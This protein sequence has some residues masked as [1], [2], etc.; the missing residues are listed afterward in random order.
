MDFLI[1][2]IIHIQCFG[3]LG[4]NG[5]GKTTLF[6]M[7][8]GQIIPT[9]GQAIINGCDIKSLLSTNYQHLGYCPQADALD[10]VL[11][12]L[13]HLQIYAELR[14]IPSDKVKKVNK[15]VGNLIVY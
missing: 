12:P 10:M 3:L 11:S 13:Q 8:T 9:S 14:G 5:A 2:F 6:R 4:V 1:L 7:L 15:V